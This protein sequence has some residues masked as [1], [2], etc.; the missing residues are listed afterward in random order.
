MLALIAFSG[1]SMF[2]G[3]VLGI[4]FR[5]NPPKRTRKRKNQTTPNGQSETK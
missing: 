2:A 4:T 5:G 1:L 3:F